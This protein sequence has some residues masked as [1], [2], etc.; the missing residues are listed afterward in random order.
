MPI[1]QHICLCQELRDLLKG[2]HSVFLEMT[3]C[4]IAYCAAIKHLLG[5]QLSHLFFPAPHF[6]IGQIASRC[7]LPICVCREKRMNQ[8]RSC[9]EIVTIPRTVDS[10]QLHISQ[11]FEAYQFGWQ[12]S[13]PGHRCSRQHFAAAAASLL[14]IFDW[15]KYSLLVCWFE[16][17]HKHRCCG[18]FFCFF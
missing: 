18:G 13:S 5:R 6:L 3:L 15:G 9:A 2:K 12:S 10:V 7:C 11:G 14:D 16:L 1:N 4:F 8:R 17:E